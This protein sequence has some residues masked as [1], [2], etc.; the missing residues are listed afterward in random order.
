MNQKNSTYHDNS[1]VRSAFIGISLPFHKFNPRTIRI[2][3]PQSVSLRYYRSN[4]IMNLYSSSN[5]YNSS[6]NSHRHHEMEPTTSHSQSKPKPSSQRIKTSLE[7]EPATS[8]SSVVA[9][10][11]S[12]SSS[13]AQTSSAERKNTMHSMSDEVPESS[14]DPSSRLKSGWSSFLGKHELSL[15]AIR[16]QSALSSDVRYASSFLEAKGRALEELVL[17]EEPQKLV[18]VY[19]EIRRQTLFLLL[20]DLVER[21]RR[22]VGDHE[23]TTITP[24]LDELAEVANSI[25]TEKSQ[26]LTALKGKARSVLWKLREA[27][28]VFQP[29]RWIRL[30]LEEARAGLLDMSLDSQNEP[31][32]S[33]CAVSLAFEEHLLRLEL[34]SL[35]ILEREVQRVVRGR[36]LR[37]NFHDAAEIEALDELQT[38]AV[39]LSVDEHR[40][41]GKSGLLR[42][43]QKVESTL[44]SSNK[45]NGCRIDDQRALEALRV[46]VVRARE[47]DNIRHRMPLGEAMLIWPRTQDIPNFERVTDRL[48]RGGQPSL[49]GVQWLLNY[50]VKAAIDLRGSDRDNQWLGPTSWQHIRCYN[51]AIEDFAAPSYEQ[52]YTFIDLVND[53]AN[54]P[55]FVCCKAGI[56]RTGSLIACW[57]ISQGMS[58][59]DALGR[60]RLYSSFGGGLK[61]ETFVREFAAQWWS[62]N[63]N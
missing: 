55:V 37:E 16:S 22:S 25:Q 6:N 14:F 60:E 58:V 46:G 3:R 51:L 23:R 28:D 27:L 41:R 20:E 44:C 34:R 33:P 50:G 29:S 63:Q 56:G 13:V 35:R 18:K 40:V 38:A 24:I 62:Q 52:V 1:P 59:D 4:Q 47:S 61:Q 26:E 21:V 7:A 42:A 10:S 48:L 5:A 15:E 19:W 9:S 39:K 11:S 43:V 36:I 32:R 54:S 53:R 57:R 12:T 31:I 49:R 17:D 30:C 45:W 2:T 8:C